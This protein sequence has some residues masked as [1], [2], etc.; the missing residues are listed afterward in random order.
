MPGILG[1]TPLSKQSRMVGMDAELRLKSVP[2]SIYTALTGMYNTQKQAMPNAIYMKIS[3]KALKN[4]WRTRITRLD[5]LKLAGVFGNAQATGTEEQPSTR[6]AEVYYHNCRKVVSVPGYGTE[7]LSADYLGLF[8]Q[9]IDNLADWNKEQE[10]LEIHQA[11][12][13][14]FGNTLTDANA[15]TAYVNGGPCRSNWN[16]N[17]FIAGIGA[18]S[19]ALPAYNANPATFSANIAAA[20]NGVGSGLGTFLNSDVLSNI[21]N[22]ALWKRIEPLEIPSSSGKGYVLTISELQAMYLGDPAWSSK[23]LGSLFIAKAALNEKVMNWPGVLGMYKDLL[24]VVDH[25]TSAVQRAGNALTAK[26]VTHGGIDNRNRGMVQ[27]STTH[28]HI[29]DVAVLHGKGAIWKW[30]PEPIH[31]IEDDEDYKKVKGVGTACARG[32]GIPLW[33]EDIDT[34]STPPEQ[35]TS[36]VVLCGIPGDNP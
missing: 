15:D 25:R 8:E 28:D 27:N 29:Y 23:N 32:I 3:E 9:H 19:A 35:N 24:L 21:S 2:N 31:H 6:V 16:P 18:Q 4:A 13:E 1:P 34:K 14:T 20:L 7:K 10:D 22:Y 5:R 30:E 36:A 33:W 12:L 11:L 26:Y 17:I